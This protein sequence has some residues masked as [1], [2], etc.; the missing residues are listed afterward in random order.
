MISIKCVKSLI[1]SYK[2]NSP[3][4]TW[5]VIFL[6]NQKDLKFK[7][8]V[9]QKYFSCVVYVDSNVINL[10]IISKTTVIIAS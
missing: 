3:C 4:I 7:T 6:S 1:K 9:D 2:I 8:I 10:M 5:P